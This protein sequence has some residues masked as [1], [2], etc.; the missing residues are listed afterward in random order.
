M[1]IIDDLKTSVRCFYW[2]LITVAS[3]FVGGSPLAWG[4]NVTN[5]NIINFAF[6]PATVN[7]RVNDS[8]RSTWVGSPHSATSDTGLWDSGVM[9]A[10]ASFTRVFTSAGYF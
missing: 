3:C 4:A 2:T 1:K 7:I 10:G 9:G 5:V 6:S 8:V